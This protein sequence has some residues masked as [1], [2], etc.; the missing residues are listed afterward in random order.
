MSQHYQYGY[1]RCIEGKP[2]LPRWEFLWRKKTTRGIVFFAQINADRHRRAGRT[3]R[4]T[5]ALD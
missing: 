2:G 5:D 4:V 1:L 3:I